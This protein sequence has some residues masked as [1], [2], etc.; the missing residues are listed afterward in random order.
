[1]R[2]TSELGRGKVRREKKKRSGAPKG[3]RDPGT[4]RAWG[5]ESKPPEGKKNWPRNEGNEITG[6]GVLW[7][8][9]KKRGG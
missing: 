4:A 3:P 8:G 7:C 5:E 9:G 6:R 2:D 1:L